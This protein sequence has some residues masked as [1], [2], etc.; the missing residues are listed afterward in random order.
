MLLAWR[1]G[2]HHAS[3]VTQR[4][5]RHSL[6]TVLGPQVNCT[7]GEAGKGTCKLQYLLLKFIYKVR[8]SVL[9]CPHNSFIFTIKITAEG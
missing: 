5:A 6:N 9:H 1:H 3:A 8:W 4:R 7:H 2:N